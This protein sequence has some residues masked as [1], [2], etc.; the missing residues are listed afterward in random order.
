MGTSY[1]ITLVN[2]PATLPLADLQVEIESELERVEALAST[3][4]SDSE[5]S[6]LNAALS[7]DWIGVSAELCLMLSR[8]RRT[9][10]QSDGAFDLTVGPL[11][12]LWGFGSHHQGAEIPSQ[13]DIDIALR[14]IGF[15]KLQLDCRQSRVRKSVAGMQIDLS[16]WAKG[17]AVDRVAELIARA[18]VNDFL[19]EIGGELRVSG[20]NRR[21]SPFKI[22]IEKPVAGNTDVLTILRITNGG[23]ATSGNYR[24]FFDHAGK[25]YSHTIDPR[26]GWPVQ[27]KLAS[28]T[29][30]SDTAAHADALATALLVL[31]PNAGMVMA[32]KQGIAA[33]FVRMTPSGPL[34]SRS[35]A[36]PATAI[37]SL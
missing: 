20:H 3:Y 27:H 12:S 2:P 36:L 5:L 19:V 31:G 14:S 13:R 29:V 22:G 7:N 26:T 35:D 28:V 10:Q 11:V 16:G 34:A 37:E 21:K 15:A 18:A 1:S 30:M 24:N 23:I 33:L 25:R 4:R 9:S 32:N 8:A 6:T 17:H